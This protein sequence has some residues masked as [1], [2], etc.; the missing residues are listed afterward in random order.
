[1]RCALSRKKEEDGGRRRE[2]VLER[3]E[4]KGLQGYY[5]DTARAVGS[6]FWVCNNGFFS[7]RWTP[8]IV[9]PALIVERRPGGSDNGQ[10]AAELWP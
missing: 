5:I 4:N 1:M 2:E 6:T 10:S 9:D 7:C 8:R 3:A